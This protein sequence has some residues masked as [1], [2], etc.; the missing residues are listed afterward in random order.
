VLRGTVEQVD[1][2]DPGDPAAPWT[3]HRGRGTPSAP[4]LDGSREL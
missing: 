1:R 4:P 3:V 2:P